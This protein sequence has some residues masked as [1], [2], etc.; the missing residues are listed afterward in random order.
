V[1]LVTIYRAAGPSDADCISTTQFDGHPSKTMFTIWQS[2]HNRFTRPPRRNFL[3]VFVALSLSMVSL[4]T[5]TI[6]TPKVEL[7]MK[8]N[9]QP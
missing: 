4:I 9:P 2:A 6:G 3:W 8:S 1:Q 7:R 5:K